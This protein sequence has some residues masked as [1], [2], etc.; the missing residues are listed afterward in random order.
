MK[1][2]VLVPMIIG[3][4][5]SSAAFAKTV[6]VHVNGMV[7]AFCGQGIT[8]KFGARPEV[9]K[10]D[11]NLKD[12]IVSLSVKDGQDLKDD[13]IQSILKASGYTVESIERK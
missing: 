2:F 6:N 10:V 8:K 11:V 5:T 12:K 4:V 1:K 3:L 13:D 7:C 9:A